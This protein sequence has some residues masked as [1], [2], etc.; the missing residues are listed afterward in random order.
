VTLGKLAVLLTAVALAATGQLVLKH[1]MVEAQDTSRG[2]DR[3]LLLAAA[4]SPWIIG[5]LMIFA[6][7]AVAWLLTLARIPLSVAYPFNALGY[8]AILIASTLV[9]HERTNLWMW[10]GTLLVGAGLVLIVVMAPA[11]SASPVTPTH[12]QEKAATIS[13]ADAQT[14]LEPGSTPLPPRRAR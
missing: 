10:L 12:A 6:A 8:V 3:S 9:L 2:S 14:A 7:S 11:S 4:S 13:A 5:G 1:G